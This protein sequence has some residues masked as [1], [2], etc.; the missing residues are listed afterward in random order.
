MYS[1]SSLYPTAVISA[2]QMVQVDGFSLCSLTADYALYIYIES[3]PV[4]I[5]IRGP[6]WVGCHKY[7]VWGKAVYMG[8]HMGHVYNPHTSC[9]VCRYRRL[10][11]TL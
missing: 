11:G 6:F 1:P 4:F 3:H 5:W 9:G 7:I 2:I 10:V 8:V